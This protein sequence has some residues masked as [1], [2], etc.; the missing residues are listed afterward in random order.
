M[1]FESILQSALR[2]INVARKF[3]NPFISYTEEGGGREELQHR[4]TFD[5]RTEYQCTVWNIV[6][7]FKP[8][9]S[10]SIRE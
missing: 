10:V 9:Q 3:L 4:Y 7:Y 5:T 1:F 2:D 6:V 8:L